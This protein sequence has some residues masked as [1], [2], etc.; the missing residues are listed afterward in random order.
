MSKY[1]CINCFEDKRIKEYI[2]KDGEL[3]ENKVFKCELCEFETCNE[4]EIQDCIQNHVDDCIEKM[5]K[6]V[7]NEEYENNEIIYGKKCRKE[8]QEKYRQSCINEIANKTYI[9]EYD[10]LIGK[11]KKV[12]ENIYEHD[13]E[14]EFYGSAS[15]QYWTDG[16]DSPCSIAGL[17]STDEICTDIFGEDGEKI[18]NDIYGFHECPWLCR[19]FDNNEEARFGK[20]SSFC[21][22]VKH[23]TR[24]FDH[25]DF[26]VKEYLDKFIDFFKTIEIKNYE[27]EIFRARVID[28]TKTKQDIIKDPEKELG[29]VPLN[30]LKYAKNNRFSPIGISYG[31]YSFDKHTILFEARVDIDNEVAIGEFE[32][33]QNLK[34]LDFRNNNLAKY[35]NPYNDEFNEDVYCGEEFIL[36]FLF[37]ISKPIRENDSL[38]E[39]V[40]TQILSEYICS[41]GYD[42]FI[43]DSSQNK[44]GENLVLFGDN[45]S[46]KSHNFLKIKEK[47]I[48]YKYEIINE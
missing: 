14:H 29:K 37:D 22:N 35:K 23:R 9:I 30:K 20:W 41:L 25:K 26:K 33:S 39:Y 16:I 12:V 27:I 10:K 28:S 7:S 19:C 11:I 47:N 4:D 38:L 43:F 46:Y 32:L 40:P 15:S 5:E 2:K 8:C 34:I 36:Y 21:E 18:L 44:G 31:Y 13:N 42:G 45:P 3:I 1:F 48:T 24:Y 6:E 17:K